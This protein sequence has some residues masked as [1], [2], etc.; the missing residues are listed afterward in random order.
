MK[1][2]TEHNIGDIVYRVNGEIIIHAIAKI[3]I[4]Y[5][6]YLRD[7]KLIKRPQILYDLREVPGNSSSCAASNIEEDRLFTTRQEAGEAW[8]KRNGLECG[9]SE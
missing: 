2:D 3:S 4:T 8:M 1:F 7:N 6:E 5:Q 9:V